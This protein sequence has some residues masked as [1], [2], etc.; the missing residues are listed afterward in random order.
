MSSQPMSASG[1]SCGCGNI[2]FL[3]SQPASEPRE[4][5]KKAGRKW[6]RDVP[7]ALGR[8][9]LGGAVVPRPRKSTGAETEIQRKER[10]PRRERFRRWPSSVSWRPAPCTLPGIQ[11]AQARQRIAGSR[12]VVEQAAE[13]EGVEVLDVIWCDGVGFH[14]RGHAF[15]KAEDWLRVGAD[16]RE[17][18][19][20]RLA[21]GHV[22][23]KATKKWG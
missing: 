3:E 22:S 17:L 21:K 16:V 2:E 1:K 19:L 8:E 14:L 10:H 7:K 6:E 5:K 18:G 20:G 9:V 4:R 23:E 13:E 15:D 11:E 12:A